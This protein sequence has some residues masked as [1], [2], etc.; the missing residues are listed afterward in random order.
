MR[1]AVALVLI[2]LTA[3]ALADEAKHP[4]KAAAKPELESASRK[5]ARSDRTVTGNSV[6]RILSVNN[7]PVRSASNSP[8]SSNPAKADVVAS[9]ME[10]LVAA[11]EETTSTAES[12]AASSEDSV[13]SSAA[14]TATDGE[15][16]R[17][18]PAAAESRAAASWAASSA[19]TA[20]IADTAAIEVSNRKLI[21]ERTD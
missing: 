13:D 2:G 8:A 6:A 12:R 14:A 7:N 9:D 10:G 18:S 16:T 20:S 11:A 19:E 1:Q 4:K 21:V 3:F 17:A 5:A 15:A